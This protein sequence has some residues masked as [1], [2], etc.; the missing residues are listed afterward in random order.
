MDSYTNLGSFVSDFSRELSAS[1]TNSSYLS[2]VGGAL[3][4]KQFPS[5]DERCSLKKI[6]DLAQIAV[7]RLE[8]EHNSIEG[9]DAALLTRIETL[10]KALVEH[11]S[12]LIAKRDSGWWHRHFSFF[13]TFFEKIA[14]DAPFVEKII[15]VADRLFKRNDPIAKLSSLHDKLVKL[16]R[17]QTHGLGMNEHTFTKGDTLWDTEERKSVIFQGYAPLPDRPGSYCATSSQPPIEVVFKGKENRNQIL[18]YYR[19]DPTHQL[20]EKNFKKFSPWVI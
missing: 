7:S 3:T 10:D 2:D 5:M 4:N 1:F 12:R 13:R 14:H 18:F 16:I 20:H 8:S 17:E 6:N 19:D 9:A 15:H 11:E